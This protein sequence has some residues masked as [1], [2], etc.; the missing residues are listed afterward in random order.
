MGRQQ[1]HD[2]LK[3]RLSAARAAQTK[4]IGAKSKAKT[5]EEKIR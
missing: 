2:L 5:P 3:Q 1:Y 4:A